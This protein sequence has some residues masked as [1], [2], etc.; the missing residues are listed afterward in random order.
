[1]LDYRRVTLLVACA[2]EE[3][4]LELVGSVE[5]TLVEIVAPTSEVVVEI[6]VERGQPVEVGQLLVRLDPI[7][8]EAEIARAQATLAGTQTAVIVAQ[9]ELER[10]QD[11]GLSESELPAPIW[12]T[13]PVSH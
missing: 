9:H 2:S 8:A 11:G 6:A 5:R 12:A 7:L 1:M 3:R 13:T 4:N 10:V